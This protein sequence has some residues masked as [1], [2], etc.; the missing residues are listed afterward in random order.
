M[1]SLPLCAPPVIWGLPFHVLVLTMEMPTVFS[2]IP[3][4]PYPSLNPPLPSEF[5]PPP[6]LDC[7]CLLSLNFTHPLF[8]NFTYPL[9]LPD[10]CPLFLN[11]TQ[12]LFMNFT[13]PPLNSTHP[14][15]LYFT[16]LPIQLTRTSRPTLWY[17]II[18]NLIAIS[19]VISFYVQF[20]LGVEFEGA[21]IVRHHHMST[22]AQ[23]NP[24]VS[25]AAVSDKMS[26]LQQLHVFQFGH[27]TAK[28]TTTSTCTCISI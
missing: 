20:I 19:I 26:N 1:A 6:F 24:E 9:L 16:P 10:T 2:W 5:H 25:Q 17:I 7:T 14:L 12:P 3:A 11:F 4:F 18:I 15:F 28:Q 23:D 8:M 22:L 13:H 27:S 21:F